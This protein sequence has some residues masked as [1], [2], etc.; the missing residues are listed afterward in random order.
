MQNTPGKKS[1]RKKRRS[2]ERIIKEDYLPYGIA[3]L[4]LLLVIIFIGNA[5]GRAV[6]WHKAEEIAAS[7]AAEEAALEAQ[8]QREQAM[9]QIIANADSMMQEYNFEGARTLLETYS[10][11]MEEFPALQ[12]KYNEV[13]EVIDSLV[14]WDDLSQ[15]V[16]LSFNNLIVDPSRAFVDAGYGSRYRSS[17]ITCTEF[18]S[19]LGELYA[20]GYILIDLDDMVTIEESADGIVSFTP[21]TLYLPQGKKPLMISETNVNYYAYM[22]DGNNDGVA[23]KN[24]DGFAH[25]LVMDANGSI[26][27]QYVNPNGDIISGDF[28]LV[29][30]LERFIQAHPEFSYK[31]AR[32]ILAV[33][34]CE[35]IF[36]YRIDEKSKNKLSSEDYSQEVT[37]ASLL[38]D[39][40]RAKGYTIASYT[41]GNVGYGKMSLED[42]QSDLSRW[43]DEIAPIL[44]DVNM[45]VYA[46]NS[47]LS[48]NDYNSA[49]YAALRQAGF[50]SFFG[51]S[52]DG[53]TWAKVDTD[54]LRQD[55]IMVNGSNLSNNPRWFTGMFD[56]GNIRDAARDEQA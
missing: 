7:I 43:H 41:Y 3:A 11:E 2:L 20:N 36:G 14:A 44:S 47:E 37:G 51:Y 48:D 42:I 4:T 52:E 53:S 26:V 9:L 16:H 29:P 55:R 32:A 15:V 22:V 1:V 56:A 31:G 21:K 54:F 5:I 25:K 12:S 46:K 34:G 49:K 27:A 8:R 50:H 19:I 30:I 13:V 38:V 23:D 45:M 24:G 10:T 6:E 35:G 33:S 18:S 40:L 28:D 39:A 17:H